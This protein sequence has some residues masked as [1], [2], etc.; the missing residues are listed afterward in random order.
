[1]SDATPNNGQ[2][3]NSPFEKAHQSIDYIQ[4][5]GSIKHP[6]DISNQ[7]LELNSA[8]KS[9]LPAIDR[10]MKSSTPIIELDEVISHEGLGKK[11]VIDENL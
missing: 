2:L 5:T 7:Q 6:L 9:S 10:G 4:H 1:M 8:R 11:F 3:N